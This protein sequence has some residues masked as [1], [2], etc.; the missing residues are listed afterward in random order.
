MPISYK[1]SAEQIE[2][3]KVAKK[4]NKNKNV[5][6]R[7]T[8]LLMRAEGKSREETA[9][10][11]GYKTVSIT[12]LTA[13]YMQSGI[14]AIVENHHDSNH[15]NMDYEKE[16]ELLEQFSKAAENGQVVEVS[17]IKEAYD[18]IVGHESGSG[19]IY[20]VL[21]RHGWR[22]VMPR[23]K[24]PNKASDEAIEASKKLTKL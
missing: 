19:Q 2:E 17:M 15:R 21:N 24:H 5:D 6:K 23:S 18:K 13:K 12:S 20:K 1:F 7:L 9:K 14:N 22:K 10:V 16:E 11:T 8:A 3:L 4:K